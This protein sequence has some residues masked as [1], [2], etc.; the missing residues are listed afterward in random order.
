[1]DFVEIYKGL[2]LG[3]DGC[4]V[5]L[6]VVFVCLLF[7]GTYPPLWGFI[8]FY[9]ISISAMK[10]CFCLRFFEYSIYNNIRI[11]RIIRINILI[12]N[13]INIL[14]NILINIRIIIRINN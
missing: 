5:I 2:D 11:N 4:R 3:L 7:I 14:I 10:F 9:K 6:Y 13:R 8:I 1:M 12:N